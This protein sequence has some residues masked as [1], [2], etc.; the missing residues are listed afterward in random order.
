ML[1]ILKEKSN[2]NSDK[3]PREW[4]AG[5]MRVL[6][7]AKEYVKSQKFYVDENLKAW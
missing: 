5:L 7:K 3:P 6:P 4:G 1:S 2:F